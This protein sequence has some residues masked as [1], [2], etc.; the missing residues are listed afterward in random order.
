[1]ATPFLTSANKLYVRAKG[2]TATPALLPT[3][4]IN[5]NLASSTSTSFLTN[6]I[7]SN[8]TAWGQTIVGGQDLGWTVASE[9]ISD[10]GTTPA[11][12]AALGLITACQ[13]EV[14]DSAILNFVSKAADGTAYVA[15]CS[16]FNVND[17]QGETNAGAAA[18]SFEIKIAGVPASYTGPYPT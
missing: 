15:D 7:G 9:M 8:G 17:Q 10:G 2:S 11:L 5:K 12:L 18:L 1:M 14:G 4:S 13:D 3:K 16:V 6:N